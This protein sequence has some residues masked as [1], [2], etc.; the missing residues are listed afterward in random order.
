MLL[1]LQQLTSHLVALGGILRSPGWGW[2]EV[3]R[4]YN[5][6]CRLLLDYLLLYVFIVFNKPFWFL[7]STSCERGWS[8]SHSKP[9]KNLHHSE[10]LSRAERRETPYVEK[11]STGE[12][13]LASCFQEHKSLHSCNLWSS[14][15]NATDPKRVQLHTFSEHVDWPQVL[16]MSFYILE[17]NL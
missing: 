10:R 12:T 11:I 1:P 2:G 8:C 7:N 13:K 14:G 15:L 17:K 5:V 9:E 4:Q 16:A 6:F 3:G